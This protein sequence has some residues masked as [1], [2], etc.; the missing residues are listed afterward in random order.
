MS[1]VASAARRPLIERKQFQV[2][3]N[4]LRK[5]PDDDREFSPIWYPV[6]GLGG[7]VGFRAS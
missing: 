7:M 5:A 2:F 3:F 1:H 4:N 6:T